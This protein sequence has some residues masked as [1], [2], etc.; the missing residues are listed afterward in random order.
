MTNAEKIARLEEFDAYL[1]QWE[2]MHDPAVRSYLNKNMPWARQQVIEARCFATLTISPPPA[3]GGLIMRGVDPFASLFNPP[4]QGSLAS[5]VH[6]MVEQTIG[7]LSAAPED[8]EHQ[9]DNQS[10]VVMDCEK[11]YA[12]IAMPMRP[13]DPVLE[14]VLD[15][16]KEAASRCGIH[17]ERID[18]PESNE[19]ITDRI[20][21]SIRK[22]EFVVADLTNGRP[23]VFYEAGYAQGI[24]KT[25]IYIASDGTKVEFDLKD[26]PVIYFKNMKELKKRLEKRFRSLAAK[27]SET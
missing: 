24:G 19:R 1:L 27:R 21:E 8:D 17:A 2:S 9:D 11:D 26:Y 10:Q 13:D 22:A 18:E 7:V 5:Y 12:F 16:I 6:D 23:N 25:P 4:H 3:V 20:L 14:D 15:A